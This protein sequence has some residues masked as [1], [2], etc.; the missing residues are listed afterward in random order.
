V[1]KGRENQALQT[2]AKAHANG[3]INDP[4]V[5]FEMAEIKEAIA[6][7]EEAARTTNFLTLIATK[8]NRKRIMLIVAIA[9]CEL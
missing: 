7:E 4:L 6:M 8:G 2:L 9:F 3:D 1:R 5:S